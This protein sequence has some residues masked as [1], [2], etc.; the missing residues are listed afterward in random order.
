[1]GAPPSWPCPVRECPTYPA[2]LRRGLPRVATLCMGVTASPMPSSWPLVSH[3]FLPCTAVCAVVP[4]PLVSHTFLPCSC[5]CAVVSWPPDQLQISVLAVHLLS[6][7]EICDG[8]PT[9]IDKPVLW[10]GMQLHHC[11]SGHDSYTSRQS[12]T[13]HTHAATACKHWGHDLSYHEGK[14]SLS[15]CKTQQCTTSKP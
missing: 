13:L 15:S 10:T 7:D 12:S 11:C 1:M 6:C 5:V 8:S 2:P 4:Q 3:T 14:C 9:C